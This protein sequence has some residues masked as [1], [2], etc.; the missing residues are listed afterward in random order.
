MLQLS[1][2]L[3]IRL[4][5]KLPLCVAVVLA[6]DAVEDNRVVAQLNVVHCAKE[7]IL[8]HLDVFEFAG[9]LP[10]VGG[11]R[12]KPTSRL[13]CGSLCAVKSDCAAIGVWI[14]RFSCFIP[15]LT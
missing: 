12:E 7:A 8:V 4:V 3:M 10:R 15:L 6:V 14:P 2:D 1:V 11:C 13:L 9:E 5:V